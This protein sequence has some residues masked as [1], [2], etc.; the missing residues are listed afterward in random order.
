MS[1]VIFPILFLFL[2]LGAEILLLCLARCSRPPF[3]E[4]GLS[5]PRQRSKAEYFRRGSAAI[6]RELL[7][8]GKAA[9][10]KRIV[11]RGFRGLAQTCSLLYRRLAACSAFEGSTLWDG[12][13]R[14]QC[15]KLRD[16]RKPGRQQ[17][18]DTADCKSALRALFRI[19]E[20]RAT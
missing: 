15:F 12:R 6:F 13:E 8:T 17:V 14:W 19:A 2:C 10:R 18:C 4:R 9:L 1:D 16:I 11:V 7:R 5:S 20:W 3:P